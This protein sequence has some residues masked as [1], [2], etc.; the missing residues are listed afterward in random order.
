MRT[1]KKMQSSKNYNN[2]FSK[3][4]NSLKSHNKKSSHLHKKNK[5]NLNLKEML[6]NN[7]LCQQ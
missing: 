1:T 7:R 2:K 6:M 5:I 3:C 4:N